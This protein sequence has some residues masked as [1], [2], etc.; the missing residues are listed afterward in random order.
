[1]GFSFSLSSHRT[2]GLS[3]LSI[4]WNGM[5]LI[6]QTLHSVVRKTALNPQKIQ[7]S[8][9]ISPVPMIG[10]ILWAAGN[11]AKVPIIK[12]IGLG[13]GQI[14]WA[15]TNCVFGWAVARFG[16]F[17]SKTQTPS[18]VWLNYVGICLTVSSLF[19]FFA[20]NSSGK[21]SQTHGIKAT[22]KRGDSVLIDEEQVQAPLVRKDL[23]DPDWIDE[24]RNSV[25]F[26]IFKASFSFPLLVKNGSEFSLLFYLVLFTEWISCQS[27]LP[28]SKNWLHL[29]W[30]EFCRTS[31]EFLS[32]SF[33]CSSFTPFIEK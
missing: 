20:I 8:S 11:A 33:Q 19:I 28:S 4:L 26:L 18:I 3:A 32:P 15:S 31:P 25:N 30:T 23:D 14:I 22:M 17:G 9:L 24:V 7:D 6:N 21:N 1:M 12:M 16:L 2:F 27:L 5:N 13:V 29:T 10:G